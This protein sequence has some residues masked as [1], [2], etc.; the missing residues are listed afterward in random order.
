[1][2]IPKEFKKYK[3]IFEDDKTETALPQHQPWDHVIPL[4]E[5]SKPVGSRV[6]KDKTR[7]P[8][9]VDNWQR[10]SIGGSL[11]KQATNSAL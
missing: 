1:M 5:E 9:N 11:S 7:M 2:E 6:S 10:N 8:R 4:K 3:D